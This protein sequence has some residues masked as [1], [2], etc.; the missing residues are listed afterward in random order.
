M[1]NFIANNNIFDWNDSDEKKIK[2]K[3]RKKMKNTIISIDLIT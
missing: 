1:M 2:L 3:I